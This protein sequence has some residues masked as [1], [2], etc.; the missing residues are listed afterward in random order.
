MPKTTTA[1]LALLALSAPTVHAADTA[2]ATGA[3]PANYSKADQD[4]IGG[5]YMKL[6][7]GKAPTS[8]ELDAMLA[9]VVAVQKANAALPADCEYHDITARRIKLPLVRRQYALERTPARRAALLATLEEVCRCP[10]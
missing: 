10:R 3:T 7:K 9:E 4:K 5:I 6:K 8:A 2:P 1:L